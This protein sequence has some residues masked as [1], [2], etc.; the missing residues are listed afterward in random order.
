LFAARQ[1]FA[2]IYNSEVKGIAMQTGIG[3]SHVRSLIIALLT[4]S[5]AGA[6][7]NQVCAQ[8]GEDIA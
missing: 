1:E 6:C 2:G 5:I 4:V 8:N 3:S 7:A